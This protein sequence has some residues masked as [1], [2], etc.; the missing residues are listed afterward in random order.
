MKIKEKAEVI[1]E[2]NK[3]VICYLAGV[4]AG[5]LASAATL[6]VILKVASVKTAGSHVFTPA[7]PEFNEKS[8]KEIKEIFTKVEGAKIYDALI[9]TVNGVTKMFTR[10]AV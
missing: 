6:A 7:K 9:V 2:E 5:V 4:T 3:E 10:T 1:W 8:I